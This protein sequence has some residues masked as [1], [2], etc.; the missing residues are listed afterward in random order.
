MS[1]DD[2][3]AVAALSDICWEQGAWGEAAEALVHRARLERDPRVLRQL[4]YRL[5]TIYA[6]RMG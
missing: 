6:D 4:Y 3:R 5:G 2:L 1:P